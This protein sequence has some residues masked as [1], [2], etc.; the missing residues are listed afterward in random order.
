MATYFLTPG[1]NVASMDEFS[2]RSKGFSWTMRH[3]WKNWGK[4]TKTVKKRMAT[5]MRYRVAEAAKIIA[6]E[7]IKRC[8]HYSGAL[9][10]AIRVSEPT[11]STLTARGRIEFA[12]GVLSSWKS[13]Y[14]AVAAYIPYMPQSGPELISWIHEAYDSFIEDTI[15]GKKRRNMKQS[16]T[17]V[18]V[19]SGFLSRAYDENRSEVRSVIST[20]LG[21][22]VEDNFTSS[23]G[24][25]L[26]SAINDYLNSVA[27]QFDHIDYDGEVP[28]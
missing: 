10:D 12:V 1:D 2:I 6:E 22:G 9:E 15:R 28:F 5:V 24:G 4:Y 17:G 13:S 11:L 18:H 19:G 27:D 25:D 3:S 7:A 14:D 26:D 20:R 8:P 23:F 16:V 21:M